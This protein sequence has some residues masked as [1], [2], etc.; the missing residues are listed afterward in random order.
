[1]MTYINCHSNA[2]ELIETGQLELPV[3][4][5]FTSWKDFQL[6]R[7]LKGRGIDVEA[8]DFSFLVAMV[9]TSRPIEGKYSRDRPFDWN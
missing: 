2:R 8:V 3:D 6:P 4:Q 7:D 9:H 1:M 5:Q